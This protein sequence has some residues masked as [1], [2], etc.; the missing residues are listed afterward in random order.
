MFDVSQ[1]LDMQVNETND[2]TIIPVPAR[3]M[4]GSVNKV[5]CRQWTKKDD[6]SV[7]GLVLDI[8]WNV[9]DQEVLRELDRE[10]AT[11]KQGIM[12]D[13][14]P[15]GG[16]DCSK[17]RNVQL[18]KLREALDLNIPGQPFSF[19]MLPGR[20]AKIS[21]KHRIDGEDIF[22]EVKAVAKI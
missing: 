17:G 2:T 22:A 19:N 21:V 11:V 16:L 6:P 4:L 12:L 8:L 15:T 5:T 18:G 20:M 14:T 7:G 10:K 1:F 13:L 9:E 3:E